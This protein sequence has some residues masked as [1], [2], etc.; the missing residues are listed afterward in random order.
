MRTFKDELVIQ[1]IF[2]RKKLSSAQFFFDPADRSLW[3]KYGERFPQKTAEIIAEAQKIC[4]H[5]FDLLGSGSHY[6]GERINWHI[7]PKSGYCW[8]KQFYAELTR[9]PPI[10]NV[11]V[12]LPYELSRM[13]HLLTLGKA[14]CLTEDESYAQEVIAQINQWLDDNPCLVGV[15]WTCAM[16]VAIRIINIIWGVVFIEASTSITAEF[17]RRIFI[18]IWEHGQYLVRHLEYS[19][20]DDG[21]IANHNHYLSN[22]VGL[23][24]LGIL[25]PE[26]KASETWRSIG[27]TALLEEMDRQVYPDGVN[28]ESS[29]SYHRL[30]LELFTSAALLCRLNNIGLPETFWARLEKMYSFILYVNRPDGKVPQV[31]DADDGRLHILS[32]YGRWD[33]ADHRYLLAIGAV[34]F[35]RPD[36]KAYAGGFSED[37]FWLLG[38][39]GAEV[40]DALDCCLAPL[41]SKAFPYAGFYVM[42]SL[43]GSYLLACCNRVGTAGLG[44]HKHNDLLSFEFYLSGRAFIVDP[45]AY[46]YGASSEWRNR[47][48]STAYHN[49]IVID[50]QEQNRFRENT[51][52]RL[53]PDATPI[54]HRWHSASDH[55]FLEAEHTGYQRLSQPVS[56]RRAFL[57]DKRSA[58]LFITDT[59]TGAGQHTVDWYFHFDYQVDVQSVGKGTFLACA[60]GTNLLLRVFALDPL[61]AQIQDG[62]VSR[63][64]GVKLPSKILKFADTFSGHYNLTFRIGSPELPIEEGG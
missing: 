24:Y 26:F 12:K 56:H 50:G 4:A 54:V 7:D 34:L 51:L 32:D 8:P 1:P 63:S 5:H 11:D 41:D 6:W 61:K 35:S 30:V 10:N 52:F 25:F 27:A 31:G 44:N 19:I 59:L 2:V 40:F 20:S 49:T 38:C 16:D 28:Y 36:M 57:F 3:S 13:Q 62:W 60:G 9:V 47:F 55:D 42:R 22:I 15:N 29:T 18:T 53:W 39:G 33:R 37:A 23:V 64:Y 21:R 58:Q 14:Y 46:I 45:G 43:Q 48:R 17:K